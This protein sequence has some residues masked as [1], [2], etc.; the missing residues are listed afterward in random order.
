[1]IS[2]LDIDINEVC[3]HSSLWTTPSQSATAPRSLIRLKML[4]RT[5]EG[6]TTYI[7]TL[8]Q[9]PQSLLPHLA[10]GSWCAW[11]Y[12]FVVIC[13]LV[14]LEENERLG[15][16]EVDD[17]PGEIDNLLPHDHVP[18]EPI[19]HRREDKGLSDKHAYLGDIANEPGW[20]ALVIAREYNLRELFDQ[21]T[22]K[23]A[24]I[25]P[26]G[27][28][29]WGRP[30]EQRENLYAIAC[31]HHTMHQGFTKRINQLALAKASSS[32]TVQP[33]TGPNVSSRDYSSVDAWQTSQSISG[34][35]IPP[36][37]STV[38]PFASFMNF[39]SINFEGLTQIASTFPPQGEEM[40]GDWMWNMVMD[41]F[42]M[43]IL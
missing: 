39:D 7:R 26:E 6:A 2:L 9:I 27:S 36:V 3:L 5:M 38:L 41:D 4:H 32:S 42:T 23:L 25:L 15:D 19:S 40:L 24:F 16:T 43:P 37:G 18:D 13:K 8:L 34:S 11:F 28:V 22:K 35:S 29:L 1:M 30:K 17:I 20:N 10:L 33:A 14:F 21:V 31:L 12:A